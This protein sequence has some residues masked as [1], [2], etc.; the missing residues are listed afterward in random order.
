MSSWMM[1]PPPAGGVHAGP[2]Y[3][4]IPPAER[5]H[6]KPL[7]CNHQRVASRL[8]PQSR[9]G[10]EYQRIFRIER[11]GHALVQS[12]RV[13]AGSIR[14]GRTLRAH[15]A[16]FALRRPLPTRPCPLRSLCLSHGR[17]R[18]VSVW[19]ARS[20][21]AASN[22]IAMREHVRLEAQPGGVARSNHRTH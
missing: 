3:G 9:E 21:R 18:G 7:L 5:L 4:R 20:K 11:S 6:A 8:P 13:D 2:M 10:S 16:L 1:L 14:S 17:S 22:I 15:R 19:E 12:E